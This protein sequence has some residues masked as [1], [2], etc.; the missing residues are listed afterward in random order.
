MSRHINQQMDYTNYSRTLYGQ[1]YECTGGAS[2]L[3]G[4][5][6]PPPCSSPITSWH[7]QVQNTH[8]SEEV[9]ASTPDTWRLRGLVGAY[10]E[11]FRIEDTMD[12]NYKTVPAC[13]EGNN[14]ANALGGGL[15]CLGNDA[16][17]PGSTT[18]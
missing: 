16:P 9:R 5:G 15:P 1:Y 13:G 17:F 10:Y 14:L 4:K 12:F 11:N 18:N 3:L 7:A 6:T 8:F 2:G